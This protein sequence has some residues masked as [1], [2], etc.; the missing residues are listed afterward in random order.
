MSTTT[1]DT[2][3]RLAYILAHPRVRELRPDWWK[4]KQVCPKCRKRETVMTTWEGGVFWCR[5]CDG[6]TGHGRRVCSSRFPFTACF[7]GPDLAHPDSLGK[8]LALADEVNGTPVEMSW[9][10]KDKHS[11]SF[12]W[13]ADGP[14]V[15]YAPTRT[16]AVIAALYRALGGEGC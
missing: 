8:L 12:R 2:P 7:A 4:E 1:L 9:N 14:C 13:F 3:A 10:R 5:D 11:C 16:D 15:C 6:S